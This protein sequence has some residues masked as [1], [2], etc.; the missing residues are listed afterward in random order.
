MKITVLVENKSNCSLKPNSL[1]KPAH[2]LS[3]YV[4]T[5]LHKLL[6]DLGPDEILLENSRILGIDLR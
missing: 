2:G 6:F 4:E 1:C 3:L 5:D